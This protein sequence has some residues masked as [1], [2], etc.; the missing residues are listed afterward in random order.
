MKDKK[1]DQTVTESN[2]IFF[3]T[4]NY[5][6][7]HPEIE[8]KKYTTFEELR[9]RLINEND[10]LTDYPIKIKTRIKKKLNHFISVLINLKNSTFKKL[11]I[12]DEEN[13]NELF[14]ILIKS[15]LKKTPSSYLRL[16]DV[17]ELIEKYSYH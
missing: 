16:E 11:N 12:T 8:S 5:I 2:K 3:D 7:N 9:L 1:S 13:K 15:F 14:E 17:Q 6:M 4:L 10:L